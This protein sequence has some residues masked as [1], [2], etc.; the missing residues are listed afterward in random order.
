MPTLKS[1]K[2]LI[3]LSVPIILGQVGQM[4]IGTGDVYIAGL[5][6]TNTVAAI[7]VANGL[8]NP[9]FLFG[10]GLFMGVS[11]ILSI[12]RAQA[13]NSKNDLYN[14]LIYALFAGVALS[15]LCYILTFVIDFIPIEA[16]LKP[17]IKAYIRVVCW[18]FPF[19][20]LY[21][22]VKEFLQAREEVFWPNFLSIIAVFLNVLINYF[23]VFGWGSIEGV[24]EIGL[25]YASVSIRVLL[26]ISVLFLVRKD[27]CYQFNFSFLKRVFLFSYPVAFMFFL[28]VLAFCSVSILSGFFSVTSA[29]TNN[30]IMNLASI[31]FMVPLSISSAAA[32]KVGHAYGKNDFSEIKIQASSALI[33]SFLFTIVSATVFILFPEPILKIFTHDMAVIKLGVQIVF[34]V[35]LFQV[36]DGLQVTLSGILRGLDKTKLTSIMVFVGYWIFG[37]PIGV[38]LAYA[39]NLEVFGLWIGLALSLASVA[40][41][42][43]AFLIKLLRHSHNGLKKSDV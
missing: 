26:F 15:V 9:I 20:Y 11:P 29:A 27:L 25:A 42:L 28:E 3:I 32:V 8:I 7:G 38:Y 37:I 10:I 13:K 14:I 36:F 24:G 21:Q 2:Q 16:V 19:A 4:L 12:E 33:I 23:F 39:H 34:V 30:I 35:A 18:S 41:L 6:S 17:S 1:L 43:G 22:G 40:I 31:V 5:Y